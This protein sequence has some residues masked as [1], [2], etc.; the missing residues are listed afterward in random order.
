MNYAVFKTKSYR[1]D[2]VIISRCKR[3]IRALLL[4]PIGVTAEHGHAQEQQDEE[5]HDHRH[6]DAAF[7]RVDPDKLREKENYL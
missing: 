6:H 3:P 5:E 2:I 7:V 1:V 4:L